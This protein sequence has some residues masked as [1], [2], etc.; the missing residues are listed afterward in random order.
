MFSRSRMHNSPNQN[1]HLAEELATAG[2]K[3]LPR[4]AVAE[5]AI[6]R[7]HRLALERILVDQRDIG[8]VDDGQI[9]IITSS[10]IAGP[11]EVAFTKF[12]DDQEFAGVHMPRVHQDFR[13]SPHL[14]TY[15][16]KGRHTTERYADIDQ[17]FTH[18]DRAHFGFQAAA[19]AFATH[20]HLVPSRKEAQTWTLSRTVGWPIKNAL[21]KEVISPFV[22]VGIAKDLAALRD[23]T[24]GWAHDN[25]HGD[26]CVQIG[27][28]LHFT[29]LVLHTRP[30]A[31]CYDLLR[32]W[33]HML[34]FSDTPNQRLSEVI[35]RIEV[36]CAQYPTQA[37]RIRAL[38]RMR[39]L[40][41][42]NDILKDPKKKHDSRY[43][44][45]LRVFQQIVNGTLA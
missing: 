3:V 39:C 21:H 5:H 31:Q 38:W 28:T 19:K 37:K 25:I 1:L 4:A 26:R 45:N 7:E 13:E 41:M 32:A 24:I 11:H 12:C 42:I 20:A 15:Y 36:F 29:Q 8:L 6:T 27:D 40:G 30:L 10:A 22:L 14:V 18:I 35:P 33:G 17:A 9:V 23:D 2:I 16:N 43:Q 34:L 44:E